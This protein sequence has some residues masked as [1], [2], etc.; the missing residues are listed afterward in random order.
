MTVTFNAN[1]GTVAPASVE[2]EP[3]KTAAL[4]IPA[5][6]EGS[7]TIFWGWYTKDGT[8]SS[9]WGNRFTNET[10]VTANITVYAKWGAT[11]PAHTPL[12]STPRAALPFPP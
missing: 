11:A 7:D 8:S 6:T 1:G 2:V 4:P 9:D 5:K 10:P 3:G 12:P